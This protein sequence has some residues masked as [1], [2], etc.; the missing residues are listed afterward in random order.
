LTVDGLTTIAENADD[1]SSS[2]SDSE[3]VS[4]ALKEILRNL[5]LP[6]LKEP[7][8]EETDSDGFGPPM[9][10]WKR[11]ARPITSDDENSPAAESD[12][13][14]Q[15]SKNPKNAKNSNTNPE[16]G[17]PAK[18]KKNA[19]DEAVAAIQQ[20]QPASSA[21]SNGRLEASEEQEVVAAKGKARPVVSTDLS[22]RHGTGPQRDRQGEERSEKRVE[23]EGT[24]SIKR[25]NQND[26]R[27]TADSD[28][29]TYVL[30]FF[31]DIHVDS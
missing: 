4:F 21:D 28:A 13:D 22:K 8:L 24:R 18:R 19:I 11:K 23:G 26:T 30:V 16:Q 5:P 7:I 15:S 14:L 9:R 2:S 12:K 20:G 25:P 6:L 1:E 29:V 27:Q 31:L 3:S 10:H 17:K